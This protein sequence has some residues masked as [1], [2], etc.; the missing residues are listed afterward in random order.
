LCAL[1]ACEHRSTVACGLYVVWAMHNALVLFV[2]SGSHAV[3]A[4]PVIRHRFN[5]SVWVTGSHTVFDRADG[6]WRHVEN[7]ESAVPSS[8][9]ARVL[10]NLITANH[11]AVVNGTLFSDWEEVNKTLGDEDRL[12]VRANLQSHPFVCVWGGGGG[13]GP[14]PPPPHHSALAHSAEQLRTIFSGR[15]HNLF[16]PVVCLTLRVSGF[17]THARQHSHLPSAIIISL[18]MPCES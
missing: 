14:P 2:L 13:G 11:T 3:R 8:Q 4:H 5:N 18:A 1:L 10:Y 7:S 6:Q 12:L 17:N 16:Y 15:A 9:R